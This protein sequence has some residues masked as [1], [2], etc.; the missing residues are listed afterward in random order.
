LCPNE[1]RLCSLRQE[2]DEDFDGMVFQLFGSS[3]RFA[4]AALSGGA[5]LSALGIA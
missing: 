1:Q 2:V 3:F 5:V 4:I